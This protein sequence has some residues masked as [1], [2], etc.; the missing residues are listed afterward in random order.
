MALFFRH[1]TRRRT[2]PH[3]QVSRRRA[4]APP[5]RRLRTAVPVYVLLVDESGST[6]V[7]FQVAAGRT[8][9]RIEAIQRAGGEYLVQL[10]A[11]NRRQ[12]VALVGFSHEA[13][14]YHPPAPVGQ[15]A[16]S[17]QRAL[18]SLHPQSTTNLSAGLDL[19]FA[20]L[21]EVGAMRG[22][23][24]L[25]TD[26]A[27]NVQTERL[28]ALIQRARNARVRIFTIGVGND[29]DSDYDRPLLVRM[30]RSTGGRF[31]S[32]HSFGALCTALRRAS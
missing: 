6:S 1:L 16:G 14:L 13:R 28:P 26:G 31:A 3:P 29:G 30:A 18:G 23:I 32:A 7:P 12:L 20:Q 25:I 5:R 19:A 11:S 4:T 24:V 21:R 22:N 17:L 10:A 9:S 27:A 8:T 15:S 2:R